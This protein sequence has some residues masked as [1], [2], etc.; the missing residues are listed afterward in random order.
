MEEDIFVE[1]GKYNA[2]VVI[3][4]EGDF[5]ERVAC[6]TLVHEGYQDNESDWD[7]ISENIGVDS[8]Q[9]GIFSSTVYPM[10][11][12]D[13]DEH[14]Y[15]YDECCETTLAEDQAGILW[16][17]EGVVASSGYGD[18]CYGLFAKR[19][20]NGQNVALMVDFN[21]VRM[22]DLFEALISLSQNS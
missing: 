8:G 4:D 6:L 11:L 10:S 22:H 15:F 19:D 16:N 9:C 20:R 5:G 2:F 3:S 14:K 21:L 17:E 12:R 13:G 7:L 1:P 18:G